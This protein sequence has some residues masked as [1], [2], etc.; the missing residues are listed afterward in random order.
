MLTDR[1]GE[2]WHCRFE[3]KQRRIQKGMIRV[4]SGMVNV[5][6]S[7]IKSRRASSRGR[8]QGRRV[9]WS[10]FVLHRCVRSYFLS[11]LH[12]VMHLC[13]DEYFASTAML[14]CQVIKTHKH[15]TEIFCIIIQFHFIHFTFPKHAYSSMLIFISN[16]ILN[17]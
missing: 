8:N 3:G 13:A 17:F 6:N 10:S 1:W 16:L 5:W 9:P 14:Y 7:W 12:S 4:A 2:R 11:I 15:C